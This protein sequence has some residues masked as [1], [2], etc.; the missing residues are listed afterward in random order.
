MSLLLSSSSSSS[1]SSSYY[2]LVQPAPAVVPP[3]PAAFASPAPVVTP[4]DASVHGKTVLR[5][6]IEAGTPIPIT[7]GSI[8]RLGKGEL[9]ENIIFY[10]YT[11]LLIRATPEQYPFNRQLQK[12]WTKIAPKIIKL[13]AGSRTQLTVANLRLMEI[14]FGYSYE[15]TLTLFNRE[16]LSCL[17]L[18]QANYVSEASA[19]ADAD[20]EDHDLDSQNVKRHISQQS[21]HP[22]KKS[23]MEMLLEHFATYPISKVRLGGGDCDISASTISFMVKN[24]C[25]LTALDF[26]DCLFDRAAIAAFDILSRLRSLVC[27]VGSY[28]NHLPAEA[29]RF[30]PCLTYLRTT[31]S[32]GAEPHGG[33]DVLSMAVRHCPLLTTLDIRDRRISPAIATLKALKEQCTQLTSLALNVRE[34]PKSITTILA[35]YKLRSLSLTSSTGITA[36]DQGFG[37]SLTSLCLVDFH[38]TGISPLSLSPLLQEIDINNGLLTGNGGLDSLASCSRLE[39]L[40]ISNLSLDSTALIALAGALPKLPQLSLLTFCNPGTITPDAIDIFM[41]V[42]P[43]VGSRRPLKFECR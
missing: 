21:E 2:R 39:H 5:R 1:S 12:I 34:I 4:T 24:F 8:L 31:A 16:R 27:P 38:S 33:S 11:F 7:L 20:N 3:S 42:W 35:T 41:E 25:S 18:V 32:L 13:Q 43:R 9:P 26:Q 36:P 28:S 29:L 10:I 19:R 37:T 30:F 17:N 15:D 6:R 22:G 23:E 40:K 14:R